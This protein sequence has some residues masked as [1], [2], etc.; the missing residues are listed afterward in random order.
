MKIE[1]LDALV[2]EYFGDGYS[3]TQNGQNICIHKKKDIEMR[4]FLV[5]T[6]TGYTINEKYITTLK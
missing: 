5:W 1:D 4:D 2:R 3:V 6:G